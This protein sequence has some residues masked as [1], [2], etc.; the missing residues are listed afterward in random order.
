MS[1]KIMWKIYM[2]L[3]FVVILASGSVMPFATGSL[4]LNHTQSRQLNNSSRNDWWPMFRHD[5]THS[6]FSTSTAPEDNQVLWSYQTNYLISSSPVVSHGRVYIGSSDWNVYCFGMDSGTLLWNYSTT[7]EITSSP[8][9]ADGRVYVGSLDTKLYCLDAID[10]TFLWD[11]DTDYIIESSPTVTD[12]KVFLS[13]NGGSLFCLNAD[14]GTLLWKYET[15]SV[16]VSSPA[17]VDGKV[18]VG[19]TN[20]MFLCLDSADGDLIWMQT[21]AE[22]T[23][24]SPTVDAGRVYFGSNDDNVYCLDANNGIVLWNYSAQ[25]EVHSSPAIAYDL[26]YI[27]TSDGRMLCLQKDIGEF[28]WSYA[29]NGGV[30]SS[31]AVADGKVYFGT[32]PCCGFMSYFFCL[33][34]STGAKIWEYNF[35]TQLN[36]KSSAA[37]AAGKVFVGS[38]DGRVFAFGDIVFL[39]DA[40]GPYHGF[41]NTSV[42]FTGSVYGGEPGFSWYWDFGDNASSTMQNPT[43]TYASIG[44]YTVTLSVTDSLGRVATDETQAF[45]EVQNQPPEIPR[46]DGPTTGN[47]GT[48]YEYAFVSSDSNGDAVFY[49]IDWGDN[50]TSGWV[51]PVPSGVALKQ[52]HSWVERGVYIVKAKAKDI[53]GAESSWS[54]PFR[55]TVIALDIGIEI[56]GGVG[57]IVTLRNTGDTPATNVFWNITFDGGI[58]FPGAKKG[59]IATIPAGGYVRVR[60]VVFGFGKP[61]ITVSARCDEGISVKKTTRASLFLFLVV[62]VQ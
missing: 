25:S 59:E 39:A 16:I 55:M 31:P 19:V 32:D 50:T 61:T 24:S 29:I 12:G 1:R 27:G 40:N 3:L 58:V 23:Y 5:L 51:G 48:S 8:A 42:N 52:N 17:V 6:G 4:S 20:G 41:V 22:G 10:G 14:D 36:M 47:V 21:M 46:V 2:S 30:E 15:N 37:V 62:G 33:N 35:N 57:V 53:H 38:G 26:L 9:V 44:E 18:Y 7:G 49:Y 43:H 60:A 45:I 11:F 13:S 56:K 28:V 34:A 54:S